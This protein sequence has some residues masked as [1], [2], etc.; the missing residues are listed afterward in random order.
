[1]TIVYPSH[2]LS[3]RI[4]SHNKIAHSHIG[5]LRYLPYA[6]FSGHIRLLNQPEMKKKLRALSLSIGVV[7]LLFGALKFVP[8][9]SPA[10]TIGSE[11]VSVLFGGFI[12]P[13][14]SLLLLALLEVVIG[15]LL[16]STRT[17]RAGVLLA[18]FHMVMTF[19]PFLI[20]PD[21][22]FSNYSI[23]APSLL[24][25]YIIKNIIIIC[26]LIVIYPEPKKTIKQNEY[27][28]S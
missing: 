5:R 21:Q 25:Q 4:H 11:T 15:T 9:L 20:F 18:F 12:T 13:S 6:Y 26:A 23:I 28:Y 7:Y 1:M 16:F 22:T 14:V 19:T 2:S 17:L 8:N 10:E 3:N 27:T 24:G